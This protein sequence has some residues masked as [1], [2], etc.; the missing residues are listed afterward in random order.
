MAKTTKTKK[1]DKVVKAT[2]SDKKVKKESKVKTSTKKVSVENTSAPTQAPTV[3]NSAFKIEKGI[4]I[5]AVS[6]V[7]G[8]SVYAWGM[9]EDGDSVFFPAEVDAEFYADKVELDKATKESLKVIANRLS[10]ATRRYTKK[11]PEFKFRIRTEGSPSGVRV[12]RVES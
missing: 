4:P 2:K 12:W 8:S 6:R 5:P 10:G 7:G 9:M 1:A 11:N 3:T